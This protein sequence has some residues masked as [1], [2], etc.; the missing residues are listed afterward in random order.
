MGFVCVHIS[1]NISEGLFMAIKLL[2][3]A[4]RTKCSTGYD[5]S[6]IGITSNVIK[7]ANI[8]TKSAW[9]LPLSNNRY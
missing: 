1:F 4:S 9:V 8:K 2:A 7:I 5:L 6:P 3:L